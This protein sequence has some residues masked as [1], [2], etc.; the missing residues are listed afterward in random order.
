M[1]HKMLAKVLMK[2]AKIFALYAELEGMKAT[3]LSRISIG[4]AIAY[5]G[6]EFTRI[7]ND[8]NGLSS[9][10]FDLSY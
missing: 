7:A 3:N 1:D 6:K 8:L 9:D 5:P 10:L 2:Q 4:A